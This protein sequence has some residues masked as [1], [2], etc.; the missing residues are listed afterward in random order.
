MFSSL[1]ALFGRNFAIGFF[2]PAL[3]LTLS[4][5]IYT[6]SID[7]TSVRNGT[8]TPEIASTIERVET[9][10]PTATPVPS[11][12]SETTLLNETAEIEDSR[13]A[14]I[15]E[16]TAGVL[17]GLSKEVS[18]VVAAAISEEVSGDI[19]E[20][21]ADVVSNEVSESREEFATALAEEVAVETSFFFGTTTIALI[22]WIAGIVL[23]ALNRDL[24][25]FYQGYNKLKPILWPFVTKTEEDA[26]DELNAAIKKAQS[27]LTLEGLLNKRQLLDEK[28]K[29]WE[30][31]AETAHEFEGI[32]AEQEELREQRKTE[33][34]LWVD[35]LI[36]QEKL[37]EKEAEEFKK[38]YLPAGNL[39]KRSMLSQI[40][41]LAKI[42]DQRALPAIQKP[43]NVYVKEEIEYQTRKSIERK[44]KNDKD[45]S[46][47]FSDEEV[48]RFK[49][50]TSIEKQQYAIN[51]RLF[52]DHFP[53]TKEFLL[54]TRLGNTI[55]AFEVYSRVI[56][57]FDSVPLY[58]RL[59][60]VM[61]DSYKKQIE[62]SKTMLDFWINL[63]TVSFINLLIFF[64][65]IV[66]LM[67][68]ALIFR[69]SSSGNQTIEPPNWTWRINSQLDIFPYTLSLEIG[70]GLSIFAIIAIA[71]LF[72]L[73]L[74]R[75]RSVAAA[76]D[77]GLYVKS[78]FDIFLPDLE[79][80]MGIDSSKSN[81]EK[82]EIWYQMTQ[83]LLFRR[84]DLDPE[85]SIARLVGETKQMVEQMNVYNTEID[86][87][88][89]TL[90]KGGNNQVVGQDG[91]S[92]KG[93]VSG[94][95]A[96]IQDKD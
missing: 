91:T 55:R 8:P 17:D 25:R 49:K 95:I 20:D 29:S 2:L 93:D 11:P 68:G 56:Y 50:M 35:K 18:N 89:N 45:I 23:L 94:S 4:I 1:P 82:R 43:L 44:R 80:A 77:W 53:D 36:D 79:K 57:G 39:S 62:E 31:E 21:V 73:L 60:A 38:I 70:I 96:K 5:S 87:D 72:T 51:C 34:Y 6:Q 9:P 86:G 67:I 84:P 47:N 66:P 74:S 7:I 10:A 37:T 75:S 26:Y 78:A 92:V 32:S 85:R 28:L 46:K 41:K 81:K 69:G 83:A 15:D 71:S 76:R 14:L 48:V 61:T 63:R 90:A 24:L 22:A 33:F 19:A 58:S 42:I 52:S 30:I 12:T 88:N 13:D 16:I 27:N 64:F 54:P 40:D 3:A 65:S 59:E